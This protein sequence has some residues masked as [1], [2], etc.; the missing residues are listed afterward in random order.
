MSDVLIVLIPGGETPSR[1]ELAAL[2]FG[3]KAAGLVGGACDA[4]LLGPNASSAAA[5]V[6]EHGARTVL[7]GDHADLAK[8]TGE[9]HA[10]AIGAVA[11]SGGYRLVAG[12]ATTAMRDCLPRV[13]ARL[14]APMASDV[15][16]LGE[17]DGSKIGITKPSFSGNLLA[18]V[19]LV[20]PAAV[21]TCRASS[22]DP[23]AATGA[24]APIKAAELPATLAHARKKFVEMNRT[25]LER[26]ELTE[27]DTVV[28]G[29]RGTRGAEGFKLLE[30]LADVLGAAVGA[31]RAVVDAGWMPN[32]F[33]VGQ[34]G[35]VIAPKLYIGCGLSGAIQHLA[36]MRNS[37][38]IVAINKDA[39]A[40]IFE[41]A[42]YGLV[43]DLFE[44]V[45]ALTAAVKKHRG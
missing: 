18:D 14:K 38:T 19:D 6:A 44:A 27:A 20:G 29:G 4:L 17:C 12:P 2:G 43:A 45:P 28:S 9:A 21:A 32:D 35:K 24:A 41:V 5:G 11:K 16:A 8:P 3:L 30:E 15:L 34:T 40:P 13:A 33:Q 42:D 10:A 7:V 36:G 39:N 22:F 31:S 25:P 23:P 26:P 37:K 1:S